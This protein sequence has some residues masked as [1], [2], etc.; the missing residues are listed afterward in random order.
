MDDELYMF[1]GDPL[2]GFLDDMVTV[3]VFD[4]REDMLFKLLD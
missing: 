4:T 1:G 2:D 3:L